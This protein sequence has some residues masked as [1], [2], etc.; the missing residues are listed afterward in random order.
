MS[1]S[2]YLVRIA[3]FLSATE[4]MK[5]WKSYRTSVVS[6]HAARWGTINLAVLFTMKKR[7]FYR[8]GCGRVPPPLSQAHCTC[9]DGRRLVGDCEMRS[10]RAG[11]RFLP[12]GLF[13]SVAQE[14][15]GSSCWADRM[16]RC[17]RGSRLG[18]I[19]GIF[20]RTSFCS[21]PDSYVSICSVEKIKKK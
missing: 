20:Q 8:N 2:I 17:P 12:G 18:G 10:V 15:H 1:G 16:A 21:L 6:A 5:T 13:S 9:S 19:Y 3:G 11:G 7:A 14:Q 4:N